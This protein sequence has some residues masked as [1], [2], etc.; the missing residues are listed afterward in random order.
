MVLNRILS[1]KLGQDTTKKV[2]K[3]IDDIKEAS[4]A[5]KIKKLEEKKPEQAEILKEVDKLVTSGKVENP[6][7]L[8]QKVPKRKVK[9]DGKVTEVADSETVLVKTKAKQPKVSKETEQEFFE[10]WGI[11]KGRIGPNILKDFNIKNIKTNDDIYRLIN[12][13]SKSTSKKIEKQ[14]RGIRKTGTTKAAAT[15]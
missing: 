13:I 4:K 12:A 15:R 14:T 2:L 6:E 8:L 10:S 5:K 1:S 3:E 11:E 7:R 9:I